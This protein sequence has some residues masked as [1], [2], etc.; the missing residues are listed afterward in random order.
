MYRLSEEAEAVLMSTN[1]SEDNFKHFALENLTTYS[2]WRYL[3]ESVVQLKQPARGQTL[4]KYIMELYQLS[5]NCEYEDM[6]DDIIRDC[7]VL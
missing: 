2:A 3:R 6:T 5:E 1:V 4:E 7:L